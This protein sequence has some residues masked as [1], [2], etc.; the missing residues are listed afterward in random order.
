MELAATG[1]GGCQAFPGPHVGTQ[2]AWYGPCCG[3]FCGGA[4]DVDILTDILIA[5][6]TVRQMG[7]PRSLR[8]QESLPRWSRE[9]SCDLRETEGI[10]KGNCG[11]LWSAVVQ[12]E[13]QKT[14]IETKR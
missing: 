7:C 5:R 10:D 9:Y 12:I 4:L 3:V 1:C 13:V 6:E 2:R 11:S 14:L 8:L